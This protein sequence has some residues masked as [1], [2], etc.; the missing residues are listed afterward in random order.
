MCNARSWASSTL[1][2]TAVTRDIPT[3]EIDALKTVCTKLLMFRGYQN[4]K[5]FRPLYKMA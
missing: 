4:L 2:G 5:L 3:W 1:T